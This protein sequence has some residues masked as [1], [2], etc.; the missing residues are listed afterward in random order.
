MIVSMKQSYTLGKIWFRWIALKKKA[1]FKLVIGKMNVKDR[2]KKKS[3]TTRKETSFSKQTT[4]AFWARQLFTARVSY[5]LQDVHTP[6]TLHII[7][8]VLLLSPSLLWIAQE[9]LHRF[10]EGSITPIWQLMIEGF[11]IQT[12]LRES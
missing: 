12:S 6:W 9:N 10:L 3:Q 5:T 7:L 4:L 1:A 2:G 8:N 11:C